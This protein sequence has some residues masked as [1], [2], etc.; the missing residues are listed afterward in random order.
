MNQITKF[1]LFFNPLFCACISI[2]FLCFSYFSVFRIMRIKH[3]LNIALFASIVCV[4]NLVSRSSIMMRLPLALTKSLSRGGGSECVLNNLP[5]NSQRWEGGTRVSEEG[6]IDRMRV[7][8][9]EIYG[10]WAESHV[11]F[12][13]LPHVCIRARLWAIT[14]LASRKRTIR[15]F[16][17]D[18]FLGSFANRAFLRT[19]LCL[20]KQTPR[21]C[22][23]GPGWSLWG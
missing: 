16:L 18:Q 1:T 15:P 6:K 20:D 3:T 9:K 11:A 22:T 10:K 4:C 12:P 17:G 19:C 5:R 14:N 23:H 7:N 2:I 21:N 8:S 13:N